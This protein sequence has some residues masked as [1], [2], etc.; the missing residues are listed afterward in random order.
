MLKFLQ[1]SDQLSQIGRKKNSQIG[2][3]SVILI[4]D[5]IETVFFKKLLFW[6]KLPEEEEFS[7]ACSC[8]THVAE[9]VGARVPKDPVKTQDNL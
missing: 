6:Q 1:Y 3:I 2:L 7:S 8:R 5:G 4:P 9:Q